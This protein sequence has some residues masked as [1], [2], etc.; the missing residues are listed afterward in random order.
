MNA[1]GFTSAFAHHLTQ[2]LEFKHQLGFYGKSR[3]WHLQK[4][5]A[6]CTQHHRTVFDQATVETWV[7]H[8]LRTNTYRSWFSYIRDFGRWLRIQGHDTA[9]VLSDQWKARFVR[10]QPYL[11]SSG[12]IDRFFTAA[13]Q[14]T[15]QSPWQWQAAAFFGLMHCCGLRTGEARHLETAHVDWAAGNLDIVAAK[16]NRSRRLPITDELINL[17]AACDRHTAEQF[18][19]DRQMFFVSS[20]GNPVD[21]ATAG[22]MFHRIWDH[23]G[24]ARP[25]RGRPPRPYDFRHHFAYANI[26]RWRHNGQDIG[27]LLPYLSR[28]MGHATFDSTYYYIHTAPDF[29]DAYADITQHTSTILPEVGFS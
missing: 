21:P 14:L 2:Y 25:L 4:F 27:S 1:Y 19:A 5:D 20:T 18:G 11:F 23:A 10:S 22:T 8:H 24:L 16:T 13:T 28:Y 9:Y 17:L 12:Q 26:E 15:V 6:Y 29:M 7:A 3:I